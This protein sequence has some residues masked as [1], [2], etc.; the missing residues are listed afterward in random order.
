MLLV[1]II[2]GFA[3][4]AMAFVYLNKVSAGV[5]QQEQEPKVEVLVTARDLPANHAIDPEKD[6][7]KQE[8]P[9][10]T[11][12]KFARL[13]IKADEKAAT[14]SRQTTQPLPAGTPLM[15]S[16]LVNVVDLQFASG[17][18]AMTIPVTETGGLGGMLVPNDRVDV[19]VAKPVAAEESAPA[20]AAPPPAGGAVSPE[21]M[22]QLIG[23]AMLKA[24]GTSTYKAEVVLSNIRII[25]VGGALQR[26][27]QEMLFSESGATTANSNVTIEVTMDEALQLVQATGGGNLPVTLLLR[28]KAGTTAAPSGG[29]K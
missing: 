21:Y 26:S 3:A 25:A 18:R 14:T 23:Q 4:T 24:R 5:Q 9:A 29:I 12:E 16:H 6:L 15:Y 10:Q 20:R 2:A 27:R 19:I 22:S 17:S 7:T 8:V 28:S 1:A 11:F 13:V